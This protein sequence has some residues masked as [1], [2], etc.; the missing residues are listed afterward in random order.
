MHEI[1][2][3]YSIWSTQ[4]CHQLVWCLIVRSLVVTGLSRLFYCFSLDLFSRT[5]FIFCVPAKIT[6]SGSEII[7]SYTISLCMAMK[8]CSFALALKMSLY[9][10]FF[11]DWNSG[12]ALFSVLNKGVCISIIRFYALIKRARGP[13]EEIFVL[14]F[15]AY[16]PNAV[17]SMYLECQNKYFPYGPKSRL[18][19]ALL[20][21][22]TNEIV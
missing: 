6:W 13:Y 10:V 8:T 15:M 7:F 14:T 16:R 17:R 20:Y 4:S 2:H 18:I 11:A 22:Y 5:D 12:N 3:V 19:R 1:D 9:F 21:V